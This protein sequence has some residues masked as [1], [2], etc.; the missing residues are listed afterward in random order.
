MKTIHKTIVVLLIL[1]IV[2]GLFNAEVAF[3]VALIITAI[4]YL[5]LFMGSKKP[6]RWS[7][8]LPQ[9]NHSDDL[10]QHNDV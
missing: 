1:C 10:I 4:F 9:K 3:F 8:Q 7:R 2:L 5:I 6:R